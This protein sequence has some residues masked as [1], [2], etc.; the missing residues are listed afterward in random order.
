[1]QTF[2]HPLSLCDTV[3]FNASKLTQWVS[4]KKM[5]THTQANWLIV[6]CLK[7]LKNWHNLIYRVQHVDYGPVIDDFRFFSV[8]LACLFVML[9]KLSLNN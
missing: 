3:L 7:I 5:I 1:M 2:V 8:Q 6:V 9:A 4:A